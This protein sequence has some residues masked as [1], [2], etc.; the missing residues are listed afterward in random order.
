[1]NIWLLVEILVVV[2]GVMGEIVMSV[3][4]CYFIFKLVLVK[5]M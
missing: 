5:I 3:F 2:V 1:M 4:F